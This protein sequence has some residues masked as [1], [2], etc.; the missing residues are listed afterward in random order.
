MG[1][2]IHC[3]IHGKCTPWVA[4]E[5]VNERKANR[6]ILSKSKLVV[7]LPCANKLNKLK[8][9]QFIPVCEGCLRGFVKQLLENVEAEE[10]IE[11]VV[12]GLKHLG[13]RIGGLKWIKMLFGESVN[14]S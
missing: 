10:D 2:R 14:I 5:H 13:E 12:I 6:I 1:E 8:G 7:C 9:S 11:R 3:E 4:C